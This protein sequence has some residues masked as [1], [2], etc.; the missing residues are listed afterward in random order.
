MS[1]VTCGEIA[2]QRDRDITGSA[3]EEI[4]ATHQRELQIPIGRSTKD[5][6]N[7]HVGKMNQSRRISIIIPAYNEERTVANVVLS[8]LSHPAVGE[9]IVVDD[10]STDRTTSKARQ[11]GAIVSEMPENCGK[12]EAM[13]RGVG[14]ASYNHICFLDADVIGLDRVKIDEIISP[15]IAG[16]YDMHIAIRDRHIQLL[17][18]ILHFFPLIGG[19]RALT[20]ELWSQVPREYR[21]DLQIEIALNYFAKVNGRRMGFK[22]IPNLTQVKKEEK[23]GFWTG[24]RQRMQMNTD[25]LRV[26]WELYLIESVFKGRWEVFR[27]GV[28]FRIHTEGS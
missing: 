25:I 4:N 12:G 18:R 20:K 22:H 2:S 21:K 6:L 7:P 13:D 11:A 17:N 8:A 14:L 19:E 23:R 27:P 28:K 15:V 9:V 10:G 1:R 3:R 26:A 5:I 24:L 16:K